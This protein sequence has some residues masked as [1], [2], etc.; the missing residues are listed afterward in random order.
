MLRCFINYICDNK[1]IALKSVFEFLETVMFVQK[2]ELP[3]SCQFSY[4]LLKHKN[5]WLTVLSETE[6]EHVCFVCVRPGRGCAK[7]LDVFNLRH[8][9]EKVQNMS[10]MIRSA[11]LCVFVL[12]KEI[13]IRIKK[14]S[15]RIIIIARPWTGL[16][17]GC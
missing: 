17:I 16:V 2:P 14:Y 3:V 12:C 9:E 15:W 8:V 6:N 10:A 1:V 11:D 4:Y 5:S 7:R 13:L